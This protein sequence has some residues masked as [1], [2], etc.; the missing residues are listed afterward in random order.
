MLG[1][2]PNGNTEIKPIVERAC[3]LIEEPLGHWPITALITEGENVYNKSFS[4][5]TPLSNEDLQVTFKTSRS[6]NK[7]H[8]ETIREI[9]FV[10]SFSRWIM[11]LILKLFHQ[12]HCE[13]KGDILIGGSLQKQREIYRTKSGNK[14]SPSS[15][16]AKSSMVFPFTAPPSNNVSPQG[17]RVAYFK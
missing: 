14:P 3:Q 2:T 15:F 1:W 16:A 8:R 11:L 5:S 6:S 13:V 7:N 9:N 10:Y 4:Q 12:K 17:L